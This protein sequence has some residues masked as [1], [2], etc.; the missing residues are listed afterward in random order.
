M[1]TET[2]KMATGTLLSA[3]NLQEKAIGTL[4]IAAYKN[5]LETAGGNLLIAHSSQ[6]LTTTYRKRPVV[7]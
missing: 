7:P 4:I 6:R 1:L 3:H 2:Q 5:R